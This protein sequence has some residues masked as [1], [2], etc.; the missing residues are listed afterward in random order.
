MK[1]LSGI[2]LAL[3]LIA[4]SIDQLISLDFES[5]KVS[6]AINSIALIFFL[7]LIIYYLF[8]KKK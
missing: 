7:G 2:I 6:V 5:N 4:L 3:A 8:S 1:K